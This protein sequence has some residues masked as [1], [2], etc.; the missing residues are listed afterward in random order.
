MARDVRPSPEPV[1]L[2]PWFTRVLARRELAVAPAV[3]LLLEHWR[4]ARVG[5][6]RLWPQWASW[7]VLAR[8]AELTG[9]EKTPQLLAL[10]V[11]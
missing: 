11:R 2:E 10:A 6:V 8:W 3:P 4:P 1:L 5:P 9:A 7:K